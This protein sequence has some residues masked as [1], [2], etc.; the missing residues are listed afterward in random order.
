MPHISWVSLLVAG[1]V[2]VTWGAVG[3]TSYRGARRRRQRED[4]WAQFSRGHIELDREL[5]KVWNRE[6]LTAYG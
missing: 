6:R 2:A 3:L 1:F 4:A 5:D